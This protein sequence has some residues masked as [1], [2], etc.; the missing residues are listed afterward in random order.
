VRLPSP[1][2]LAAICCAP[3]AVG[4]ETLQS[5]ARRLAAANRH[6]R[7]L[8]ARFVQRKHLA[9]F[10]T[11]VT[12]KGRVLF[13][14]PD[15]IRWEVLPPD[16]SVLVFRGQQ[17][18]MWTPDMQRSRVFDLKLYRALENLAQQMLV[19]LGARPAG[20][21]TRYHA[22]TLK[23]SGGDTVLDMV[24]RKKPRHLRFS[25]VRVR[26]GPDLVLKRVTL[27]HP[28]GDRTEVDFKQVR[29]NPKLPPGAFQLPETKGKPAPKPPGRQNST[30]SMD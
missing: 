19:W 11:A 10:K 26:F 18:Q 3:T 15:R 23:S 6:V 1:L 12:S 7:T 16:A 27:K 4:A 8:E 13:Q 9:L 14:R 25:R 21:L 5:F 29:R 2:L 22:V 20:D 24:P 28:D 17:A 30:K